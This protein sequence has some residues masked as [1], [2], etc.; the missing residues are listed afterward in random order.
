MSLIGMQQ[1][2]NVNAKVD[3]NKNRHR[4]PPLGGTSL[5]T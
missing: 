3:Q 5:W 4:E 2:M 1:E